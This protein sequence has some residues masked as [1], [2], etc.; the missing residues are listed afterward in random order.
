MRYNNHHFGDFSSHF[1]SW[2]E[3][4]IIM[5]EVKNLVKVYKPKKGV[6]VTAVDNVSLKLPDKGMIFLLGKSGSGKSTLLNLLGG[7]DRYTSGEIIINGVSSK[8]FKQQHFDSYRNTYVGFIFQEYNILDEFSVGSNVALAI[9]LQ[10]KKA[11]D[12]EINRILKE[13]DLEGYANRKPNELSGGQKQRVAIARALV[14]NPQIIMADEPTG[15]LDSATGRQVLDTLKKLSADKLVLIVSHDREF[16]EQ[17]ADRIIEL[18]DGKVISDIEPDYDTAA[19]DNAEALEYDQNTVTVPRGYHLTDADREAIN[20]YIASLDSGIT[21]EIKSKAKRSFRSTDA[22]GVNTHSTSE[23]KLIKSKLPVKSAFKMGSSALKYKKVRLVFTILLSFVAFTMFGLA[24]TFS[25]Y[26]HVETCTNSIMDS[27]VTYASIIKAQKVGDGI[28]AWWNEYGLRFTEEDITAINSESGYSFRGVYVP[29]YELSFRSNF[30]TGVT[31]TESNINIY[32]GSF[33]GFVEMTADDAESLGYTLMAGRLPE[34]GKNEIAISKYIYLT[35]EKT[36]YINGTSVTEGEKSTEKSRVEKINGYN[37]MVGKTLSVYGTDFT[38]TGV[39]D[40]GFDITR[41]EVLTKDSTRLNT[42]DKLVNYLLAN[43]L[44]SAREYSYTGAAIVGK[45]T[46]SQLISRHINVLSLNTGHLYFADN[47]N[48]IY[49]YNIAR[50]S[51]IPQEYITWFGERK[52]TLAE[53]EVLVTVSNLIEHDEYSNDIDIPQD[54]TDTV[55]YDIAQIAERY[56]D[57]I[58]SMSYYNYYDNSEYNAQ[59]KIVGVIDDINSKSEIINYTAVLNDSLFD[60]LAGESKG[61]YQFA[62]ASMPQTKAEIK[63]LVN[64]CYSEKD[65]MKYPMKNAVTYEL[66]TVNEVLVTFS[67]IFLYIGI[68]FA[69]FAALMLSNFIATSVA[70]K[71]HE[72]GILRAIGSRSNDVFRIFFAESFIIALIN[73]LL[74]AVGTGVITAVINSILRSKAGI[75]ITVLNF[76]IRQVAL[77]LA[78]SLIVAAVASFIPVKRIASK[79]PIDAI[80]DR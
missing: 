38:V 43:E 4:V 22:S 73:F 70:H 34:G 45:G 31:L 3:M 7:L 47:G 65:G 54:G 23:F 55:Q 18:A 67:K 6:A 72:I 63:N 9:E 16:A 33:S 19:E 13:V 74:A 8:D 46:V 57:K 76:E 58:L 35:F 78:V 32:A 53:N 41:Y 40:T 59:V 5:L 26:D 10:G 17:Y 49:T 27:N 77:L 28:N 1:M 15:A 79:K 36:G 71:K 37:D 68:G 48:D 24:D 80:R 75:L 66:D 14:K 56:K 61:I 20:A 51:D 44:E 62:I 69:V 2:K 29:D 25:A 11:T 12:S 52:Q 60:N 39:I 64:Y 21:L 42:Q 50:L 30:D